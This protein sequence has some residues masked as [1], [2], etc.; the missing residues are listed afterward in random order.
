MAIREVLVDGR[1]Q[2]PPFPA[3]TAIAVGDLL[4]WD[5]SG[6]VAKPASA[7]TDAGSAALNQ[8]DFAGL[9]CGVSASQRLSTET[10]TG[11]PQS[12]RT[13]IAE[14]IFDCDCASAT[15][16]VGDLVGV[17]RNATPLND[18]QVVVAVTQPQLAIGRVVKREGV[19]V[20]KVRCFLSAYVYGG[21]TAK[22]M[23]FDRQLAGTA[24]A[25]SDA[26]TTLTVGSSTTQVG[27]PTAARKV[28]LPPPAQSQGLVFFVVNNSAG[29]FALNIRDNADATTLQSVPQ[30]KRAIAWC[31][32]TTWYAIL[33]A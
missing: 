12:V 29:A 15:F 17:N 11:T 3:S 13:I 7:R 6:K 1:S 31:D 26:D 27:V 18:N 21:F 2:V 28:I 8:A 16:E 4:W 20:T 19:A 33:G 25:M 30:N 22:P 9:F 23:Y 24:T 10:S 32:G 5:N 14:G